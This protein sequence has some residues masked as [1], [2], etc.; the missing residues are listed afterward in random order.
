MDGRPNRKNKAAFLKFLQGS[1]EWALTLFSADAL[2][3]KRAFRQKKRIL[4]K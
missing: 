4:S 1:L 2:A 3:N